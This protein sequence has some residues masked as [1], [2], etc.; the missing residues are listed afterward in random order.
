RKVL[1][2]HCSLAH[3]GAWSGV[4][5]AL[6]VAG[7]PVQARAMDLPGHGRSADWDPGQSFQAQARAMAERVVED[8]GGPVDVLGHSFGA[9]VALR[10]AVDRPDLVRSLALYEPV[11]FT[12]AFRMFDGLEAQHDV[13]LAPYQQAWE[14]GDHEAA[15][16]AFMSV[17]GDGRP[18]EALPEVQR[19][20]F[21]SRIPLINAIRDTNYGDPAGMLSERRLAGLRCPVLLMDGGDSPVYV[22]RI[23]EALL[24]EMPFARREVLAGAAHMGVLTHPEQVAARISGFLES[25][26]GEM[27][28][29]ST[30]G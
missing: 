28:E 24:A 30:F 10:L 15:A 4:A 16:R 8:W 11:F 2:L 1:M 18:W 19:Q 21:A 22:G 26:A 3:G 27:A 12:P 29:N 9:T 6:S 23:N 13:E 7:V 14:A 17:W 25:V 20:A 5:R